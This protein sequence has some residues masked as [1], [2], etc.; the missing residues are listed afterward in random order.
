MPESL[1]LEIVCLCVP[2]SIFWGGKIFCSCPI[3][4]ACDPLKR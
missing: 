3:S 1:A 4:K 2:M